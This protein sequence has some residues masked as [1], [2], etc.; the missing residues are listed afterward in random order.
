MTETLDP[1]KARSRA[2][3]APGKAAPRAMLHAVGLDD[4]A[5]AKPIIGIANT[6]VG[7]MPCNLHLP[8]RQVDPKK[9]QRD[10]WR[11]R[12]WESAR[13][14]RLTRRAGQPS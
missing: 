3:T 6:W 2:L 5:L 7:A 13:L 9:V 10:L 12:Q 11:L 8:G 1:R 4:A 14:D